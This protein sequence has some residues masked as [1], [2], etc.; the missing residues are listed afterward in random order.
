MAAASDLRFA[1]QDAIE[2][3]EKANPDIHVTPTYGSSGNFFQQ[4]S[5]KAPFDL[6]LSAD[7][8]YPKKL[9]EQKLARPDTLFEY[10]TGKIVVWALRDSPLKVDFDGVEVLRNPDAKKIAIANPKFA[11][12]GRAAEAALK[13]LNLYEEV[14][15]RLVFG[16]N[17]AQTAQFV[18]SGSADV[19]IIALSIALSPPMRDKGQYAI[20]PLSAYPPIHQGGVVLEWAQDREAT[21]KFRDFLVSP[22]G[23]A[24]LDHFGFSGEEK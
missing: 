7:I 20:V 22:R 11:P 4:L 17:I 16:E 5:N 12:Y 23:R 1:L 14:E 9:I 15:P 6:F 21:L 24:V 10:A 19:G 3:F 18:E 2:A 8:D 13:S